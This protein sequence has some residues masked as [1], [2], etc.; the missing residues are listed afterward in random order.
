MQK[1]SLKQLM[2]ALP[3]F[4]FTFFEFKV[5]HFSLMI[6]LR[7]CYKTLSIFTSSSEGNVMEVASSWL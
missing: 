6:L 5:V 3:F 7:K 4:F 1:F 2:I